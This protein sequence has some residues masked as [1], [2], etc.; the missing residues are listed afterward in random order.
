[1]PRIARAR[2]EA[3]R[4]LGKHQALEHLSERAERDAA[5]LSDGKAERE[6]PPSTAP[7]G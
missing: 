6:A 5:R 3:T 7:D 4:S 1:M 2:A